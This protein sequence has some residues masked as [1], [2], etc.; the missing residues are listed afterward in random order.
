MPTARNELT[1]TSRAPP[2]CWRSRSLPGWPTVR[3][4]GASPRAGPSTS[5]STTS[6]YSDPQAPGSGRVGS[7]KQSRP[8]SI[9]PGGRF[10]R[11]VATRLEACT[12]RVRD[13]A[14]QSPSTTSPLPWRSGPPFPASKGGF[15]AIRFRHEVRQDLYI[16]LRC[17]GN[18]RERLRLSIRLLLCET[19]PAHREFRRGRHGPCGSLHAKRHAIR[20]WRRQWNL[21]LRPGRDLE[22]QQGSAERRSA[23]ARHRVVVRCRTCRS[24]RRLEKK[25]LMRKGPAVRFGL[26]ARL[27]RKVPGVAHR[28]GLFPLERTFMMGRLE[29]MVHD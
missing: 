3:L 7:R 23:R 27:A 21:F 26:I 25:S 9:W 8:T 13:S 17:H 18:W 10:S 4:L 2:P 15:V 12:V 20:L 5:A 11:T 29:T 24:D 28:S 16:E 22:R 19:D 6:V 1:R 14:R